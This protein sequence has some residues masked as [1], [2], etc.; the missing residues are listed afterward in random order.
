MGMGV[1]VRGD[2]VVGENVRSK[3]ASRDMH[4]ILMQHGMRWEAK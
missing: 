3:C 1:Y 4:V 2:E